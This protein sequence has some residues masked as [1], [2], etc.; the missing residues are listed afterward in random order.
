M[1]VIKLPQLAWHGRKEAQYHLPDYWQI[2]TCH[3]TGYDLPA[4]TPSAIRETLDNPIG[5]K[6]IKE[7]AR[8]KKQVVIL[9]DDLS[10]ITRTFD[11]I[12]HVLQDMVRGGYCRPKYPFYLRHR[13]SRRADPP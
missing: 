1:A 10:R 3:M 6:P 12:P 5:T 7:L 4:M 13:L 11:F 8:G 9:F 2:E